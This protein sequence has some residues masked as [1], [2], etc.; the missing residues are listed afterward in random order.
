MKQSEIISTLVEIHNLIAKVTV[1]GDNAILVG[2]ALQGMRG[3]IQAL[4]KDDA[5]PDGS[6]GGDTM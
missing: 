3:L 5:T 4:M 2:N 6:D 1:N